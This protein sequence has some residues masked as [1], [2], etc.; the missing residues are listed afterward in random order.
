MSLCQKCIEAIAD[1][2][3]QAKMNAEPE[4]GSLTIDWRPTVP[5]SE[6]K[7]WAHKQLNMVA[8]VLNL[9]LKRMDEH[10][11][12]Y[13][14]MFGR[15]D[16]DRRIAKTNVCK[17]QHMDLL[18]DKCLDCGETREFQLWALGEVEKK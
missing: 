9:E 4:L 17:H 14:E 1:A 15:G 8:L 16:L 3:N 6:C 7:F 5:E 18:L 12:A 11:K 2:I 13:H 10:K